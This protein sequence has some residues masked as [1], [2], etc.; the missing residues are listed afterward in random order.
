VKPVVQAPLSIAV[1]AFAAREDVSKI[2]GH[3]SHPS[4]YQG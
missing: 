2:I 3:R 4:L 1:L